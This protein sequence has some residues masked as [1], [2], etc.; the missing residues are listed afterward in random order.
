VVEVNDVMDDTRH[1]EVQL[2]EYLYLQIL[3]NE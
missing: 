1:S 3:P 2:R